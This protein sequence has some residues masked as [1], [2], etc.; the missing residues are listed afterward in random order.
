MFE[1]GPGRFEVVD[2]FFDGAEALE[3]ADGRF[4]ERMACPSRLRCITQATTKS[5]TPWSL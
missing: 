5:E 1:R 3:D 4:V 2:F